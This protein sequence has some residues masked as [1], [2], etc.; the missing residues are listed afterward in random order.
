[1]N[2]KD[3]NSKKEPPSFEQA[4]RGEFDTLSPEPPGTCAVLSRNFADKKIAEILSNSSHNPI[5]SFCGCPLSSIVL[6]PE[7]PVNSP[8]II[9]EISKKM[10]FKPDCRKF[11]PMIRWYYF[12]LIVISSIFIV[13]IYSSIAFSQF[14]IGVDIYFTPSIFIDMLSSL[15]SKG[16][17]N[18]RTTDFYMIENAIWLPLIS[19]LLL[20][21][22]CIIFFVWNRNVL[23]RIILHHLSVINNT[24]SW[25]LLITRILLCLMFS[26]APIFFSYIISTSSFSKAISL[27]NIGFLSFTFYITLVM[28]LYSVLCMFWHI[29]LVY[30][31]AKY[32]R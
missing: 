10:N 2:S 1:M 13:P 12:F 29:V 8:G 26:S 22:S 31:Y 5:D 7:I 3:S 14:E 15:C 19:F 23:S 27:F 21:L 6:S 18:C 32:L 9:E 30:Y 17:L 4:Q 16:L 25:E 11:Y 24:S 28:Y 20:A